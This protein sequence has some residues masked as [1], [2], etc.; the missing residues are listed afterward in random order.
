VFKADL[1]PEVAL[2]PAD[3][4]HLS[5]VAV[6]RLSERLGPSENADDL[7][8][9]VLDITLAG[10]QSGILFDLIPPVCPT[11]IP[12]SRPGNR[13]FIQEPC[14][15]SSRRFGS[16][17][18]H[19]GRRPALVRLQHGNRQVGRSAASERAPIA[20]APVA[21]IE[22]PIAR[23][24]RRTGTLMAEDQAD[25]AAEIAR[26]RRRHAGRTRHP[27]RKAT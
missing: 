4:G 1:Q 12:W 27:S 23:F 15:E 7:A 21:A 10:L 13:V 22:Q 25:V 8:K 6:M 14:H 17:H 3:D 16:P 18:P 26:T 9:D 19:A 20:A 24:I 5:A 11:T 2:A